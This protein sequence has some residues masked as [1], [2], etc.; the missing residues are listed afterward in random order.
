M[1]K[2][3]LALIFWLLAASTAQ[4]NTQQDTVFTLTKEQLTESEWLRLPPITKWK[5]KKGSDPGWAAPELDDRDWIQMDSA[6]IAS[7]TYDENGEFEGWFRFRFKFQPDFEAYPFFLNSTNSAA[8]EIYVD[9]KQVAS[10]GNTGLESGSYRRNSGEMEALFLEPGREYTMAVHFFDRI[11]PISRALTNPIVLGQGSFLWFTNSSKS[12]Q[13]QKTRSDQHRETT[14][15]FTILMSISLLFWLI[16]GL[17]RGQKHLFFIALF[18]T[19]CSL[20][21]LGVLLFYADSSAILLNEE[22]NGLNSIMTGLAPGAFTTSFLLVLSSIFLDRIP[23]WIKFTCVFLFFIGA[24][25]FILYGRTNELI[26]LGIPLFASGINLL[27]LGYIIYKGWKNTKGAKRIIALGL[28]ITSLLFIGS[29]VIG[30]FAPELNNYFPF[31]LSLLTFPIFLLI[32]V[33]LWF[34]ENRLRE[35]QKAEEVIRITREKEEILKTQNLRLEAEVQNRT[36]ELNNSLKNLKATQSQLIHSEKMASLGELTAGIAHEIQ[37]PLNFVNNFSEVSSELIDEMREEIDKG[38]FEEV[39]ALGADLK[40]NLSKINHHGKRA[41]SIVKGMLQHSRSGD[42]KKE[43]IDL[44]PL[45]DEY[46]RLAY[47]GLRAK[48]KSF[49][50]AMETDFDPDIGKISVVPQELGR[51]ILNLLTNAFYAVNQKKKE[52]IPGYEPTVKIRTHKTKQGVEIHVTDNG[53]GIPEK[54]REKVFQP[55][56]ST[57]PT[58]EGTG[59]GL[60]MSYDIITKGHGGDLQVHSDERKGTTFTITLPDVDTKT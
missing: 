32:Y 40:E 37:N 19:A 35:L 52:G 22:F 8:Q 34:K 59:L 43:P 18:T 10:F 54:V 23:R 30:N 26:G 17:N 44:N 49:N 25:L 56:F 6:T 48:D 9:G 11:G 41:D 1:V 12:S 29:F 24:P 16:W 58:G 55:F 42:G 4:A 2:R 13:R 60:S 31:Y 46:L 3:I 15:V 39:K 50:A 27:A 14:T 5:F 47:H 33:A 57:K 36:T 21:P 45:A 53:N 7:L 28:L 51:V 20:F 38:D